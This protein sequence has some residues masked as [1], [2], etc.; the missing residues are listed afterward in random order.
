[1]NFQ[2]KILSSFFW[3]RKKLE[4]ISLTMNIRECEEQEKREKNACKT[5]KSFLNSDRS[6]MAMQDI[7][8]YLKTTC[9]SSLGIE[10]RLVGRVWI[11][12]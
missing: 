9:R 7:Y 10:R 2:G 4:E 11:N 1:M 3:R 12:P 6:S 8:I 5:F